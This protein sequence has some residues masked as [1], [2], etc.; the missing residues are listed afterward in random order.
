MSDLTQVKPNLVIH[1]FGWLFIF[2][3]SL[4]DIFVLIDKWPGRIIPAIW[5]DNLTHPN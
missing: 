4:V 3:L 5:H 2:R 1:G